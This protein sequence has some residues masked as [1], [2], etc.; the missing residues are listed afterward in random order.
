M[1]KTNKDSLIEFSVQ[2]K[3]APPKTGTYRIRTNGTAVTLPGTGGITYNV[4]VG[5]K[6]SGWVADHVEPGV[7][8][9]AEGENEN[10]GLQTFC[11]Y[12]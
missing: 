7:S 10:S 11:L 4:K 1:Q 12:R 6:A 9:K 3:I 2:G 5:S 8:I